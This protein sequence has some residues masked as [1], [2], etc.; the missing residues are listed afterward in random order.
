[1]GAE[2]EISGG[3]SASLPLQE[4]ELPKDHPAQEPLL[5]LRA[6]LS[7]HHHLP[8]RC[9]QESQG[10]GQEPGECYW[11]FKNIFETVFF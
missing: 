6:Q 9:G 1:M 7:H 5:L 4:S 10:G 11:S 8:H 2:Y 3:I